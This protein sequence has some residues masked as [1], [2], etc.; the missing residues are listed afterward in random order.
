MLS[1]HIHR[2]VLCYYHLLD[3]LQRTVQI[4]YPGHNTYKDVLPIA[5]KI[6]VQSVAT[7]S[8]SLGRR[9]IIKPGVVGSCT[10]Q[11]TLFNYVADDLNFE[12]RLA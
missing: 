4:L 12:A 8:E 5:G 6:I 3:P 1:D 10:G 9:H 7:Q 2:C 11:A